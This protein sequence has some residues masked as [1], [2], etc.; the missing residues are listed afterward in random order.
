[1]PPQQSEGAQLTH[2]DRVGLELGRQPRLEAEAKRKRLIEEEKEK[3][4]L[5]I[6]EDC[7]KARLRLD[8]CLVCKLKVL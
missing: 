6:L 5:K 4:K 2:L 7:S 8:L 1:M 3:S